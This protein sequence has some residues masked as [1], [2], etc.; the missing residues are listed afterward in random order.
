MPDTCPA[1]NVSL[2]AKGWVIVLQGESSKL[3]L[4]LKIRGSSRSKEVN[5]GYHGCALHNGTTKIPSDF[6][7]IIFFKTLRTKENGGNA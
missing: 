5:T 1:I 3:T 7:N 4:G 2:D 6:S